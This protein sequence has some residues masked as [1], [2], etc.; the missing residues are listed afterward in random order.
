MG[1]RDLLPDTFKASHY[2]LKLTNLDFKDWSFNG[3]VTYAVLPLITCP[4]GSPRPSKN[5]EVANLLP[6]ASLETSPSPP[7]GSSSMLSS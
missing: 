6:T 2:D 4:P 5:Y 1:D 3:S 7:T